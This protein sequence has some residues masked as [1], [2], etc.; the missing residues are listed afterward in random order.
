[1]KKKL[2]R[3]KEGE[4]FAGVCAGLGEYFNIDPVVIRVIA[5]VLGISA[6]SGLLAYI[7]CAIIIPE[8]PGDFVDADE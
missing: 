8:K 3:V 2:Y 1:M 7:L 5:L 4:V 6:G